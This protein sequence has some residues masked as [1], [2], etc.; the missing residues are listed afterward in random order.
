MSPRGPSFRPSI[1][2]AGARAGAALGLGVLVTAAAAGCFIG[3]T[4]TAPYPDQFYYPT[5]IVVSPSPCPAGAASCTASTQVPPT[6]LYVANSD[7]DLQYNSGTLQAVDL[8]TIRSTLVEPLAAALQC[9]VA[10]APGCPPGFDPTSLT[11]LS[12][13]VQGPAESALLDLCATA[14]PDAGGDPTPIAVKAAC[15]YVGLCE[16]PITAA[17]LVSTGNQ[18]L[19]PGPCAPLDPAN[20]VPL[21]QITAM[22]LGLPF[23]AVPPSDIKAT[24]AIGAFASNAVLVQRPGG[25][26]RNRLFVTVR[27][28][29]S[30]TYFDLTDDTQA[31]PAACPV[32]GEPAAFCLDC[33]EGADLQPC[34]EIHRVGKNPFDNSRDLSLPVEPLGIAASENGTALVVAHQTLQEVSLTVNRWPPETPTFEYYLSGTAPGPTAVAIIPAPGVI[35]NTPCFADPSSN[36]SC[37]LPGFAVAYNNASEIDVFSYHDDSL[38]V[39]PRPYIT[40]TYGIEIDAAQTGV[41]STAIAIDAT[42]RKACEATCSGATL[43]DCLIDCATIPLGMYVANRTPPAIIVGQV[44]AN[45]VL[46]PAG[47]TTPITSYDT[48]DIYGS[49][50][51]EIGPSAIGVGSVIGNDGLLHTRI[52]AVCFDSRFIFEYDPEA[53][54]VDAVIRTGR[55]PQSI[56]FDTGTDANGLHSYMYVGH[57]TDSYVG[58]V[59]LDMR[60]PTTFGNM[61]ASIG[62]PVLPRES[63]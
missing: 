42:Q 30:I 13:A 4:G 40:R 31:N 32:S 9:P 46:P 35:K 55:G 22:G 49:V 29:P 48:M 6:T 16:N 10:G 62:Q 36:P 45:V 61:I 20:P 27:G 59:D 21:P 8:G 37:Y 18:I 47:S 26:P 5:A 60:Q 58:V 23:V 17:Q 3:D 50:P 57:F 53:Q 51:L 14:I 7:F 34:D 38:S 2:P 33:G 24:A 12:P 44:L 41:D 25:T 63:K 54:V 39:P 56:A 1:G 15:A 52:F 43:V 28:D 11:G 19:N